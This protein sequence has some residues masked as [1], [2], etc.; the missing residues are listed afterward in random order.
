MARLMDRRLAGETSEPRGSVER[1][2]EGG[3]RRDAVF[4]LAWYVV[5]SM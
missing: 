2:F 4:E 3:M 1:Y 5:E